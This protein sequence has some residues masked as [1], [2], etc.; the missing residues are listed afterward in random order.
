MPIYADPDELYLYNTVNEIVTQI[1]DAR[2]VEMSRATRDLIVSMLSAMKNDPSAYWKDADDR[3]RLFTDMIVRLPAHL[4]QFIDEEKPLGIMTYFDTL[5]WISK[6]LD[7]ICPF[8]K[9]QRMQKKAKKV[10][11][12]A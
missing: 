8:Q 11:V 5:H 3:E 9:E 1:E 7:T 10:T 6:N 2:N 12:G 4:N